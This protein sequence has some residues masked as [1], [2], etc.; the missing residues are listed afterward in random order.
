[1]TVM[2]D[3]AW[4]QGVG[5]VADYCG[6]SRQ[7]V[8]TWIRRHGPETSSDTPMPK[9]AIGIETHQEG[10]IHYGWTTAQLEEIKQWAESLPG[11]KAR[12]K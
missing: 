6:V 7:A 3:N 9:P 12:S 11:R 10:Y 5:K 8:H 2:V 1:M 4:Y